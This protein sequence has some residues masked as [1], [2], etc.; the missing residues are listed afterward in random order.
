ME[1]VGKMDG[2]GLEILLDKHICRENDT[3]YKELTEE[4]KEKQTVAQNFLNQCRSV[5]KTV[6]CSE[7][8]KIELDKNFP[9]MVH[10][11]HGP[12]L[13]VTFNPDSAQSPITRL[14]M[15]DEIKYD[16]IQELMAKMPTNVHTLYSDTAKYPRASVIYFHTL[17]NAVLKNLLRYKRNDSIKKEGIFGVCQA[18]VCVI[19]STQ[20]GKLHAHLVAWVNHFP[21]HK[22]LRRKLRQNYKAPG[23]EGKPGYRERLIAYMEGV[24]HATIPGQPCPTKLDDGLMPDPLRPPAT[25][26]QENKSYKN[27]IEYKQ[28]KIQG[29]KAAV[30]KWKKKWKRKLFKKREKLRKETEKDKKKK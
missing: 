22:V 21:T 16:D 14:L 5:M 10:T 4:Q 29:D 15:G 19:E 7:F 30:R 18:Y 8:E 12:N 11:K 23:K 17:V 1:E 13:W 24:V 27:Y 6:K 25:E 26:A 3:K 20:S 9:A 2:E 28:L